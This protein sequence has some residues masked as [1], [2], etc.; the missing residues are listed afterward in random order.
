MTDGTPVAREILNEELNS[1]IKLCRDERIAMSLLRTFKQRETARIVYGDIIRG[2]RIETVTR[3]I[4]YLAEVIC[5]A[6]FRG[7]QMLLQPKY[8]Q[9]I[10]DTG[11]V[12]Q[13]TVL[14]LGKLGG[15]E[16]N[17]SSDIDLMFIYGDEGRTN[18][19]RSITNREYF[20]KL[21]RKF[22][23]LLTETTD[24][25][26]CYRVDL[27]LRPEGKQGPIVTQ[28]HSALRYYSEKG[29]TWERQAFVKARPVAGAIELGTEF[30]K[31]MIPWVYRR[32]L[33][34]AD[35]TGIKALKRR[36]ERRA[37]DAGSKYSDVKTG[38]G[39][40]RDI[41]FSIQFLQLLN[42][43][44]LPEIRTGNTLD[45][46]A[47][48]ESVG[49]LTMQERSILAEN[50][51]FLRKI[52][53]RLQMLFDLQTHSLPA[54]DDELRKLAIRMGMPGNEKL[55]ALDQ[56]KTEFNDRTTLNRKIL[57]HLLHDAFPDDQD[58]DPEVDLI[59][60]PDANDE[61]IER[62]LGHYG[63][64]HV[65]AA[66][67]NLGS[68]A[69]ER[70]PFLSTRRC[71]HFLAAIAPQL[72]ATISK[73]PDPDD[74][75]LNLAL[76]SDSLGG[77]SALW[78]LFSTS[79][80]SL[81]LYVRLCASS[82]YLSRLLI[83]NPGMIDELLDSLLL[84]RL[85]ERDELFE[86]LSFRCRGA[87][88]IEP[89]LHSF[90]NSMHLRVG[91]RDI[92]GKEDIRSTTAALADIAE[93]CLQQVADREFGR[94]VERLG[95]PMCE[96]DSG[97]SKACEF[98]ILGMGKLGGREPNYHSDLDV[99][100]LYES[101]GRT[102]ADRKE[103]ETT[104]QHFFSQ[105]GQR[106]IKSFTRLD[107][108]G[109]L[110]E[111][112]PR[113]RPTGPNGEL[114]GPLDA[115]A[116]YFSEGSGQLWERQ[117]LCKARPVFGSD[118][119]R[120][121]AMQYVHEILV[122]PPWQSSF[123]DDICVMRLKLQESASEENLK[124]GEGGTVDIEFIVQMLQLKHAVSKPSVLVTGTLDTISALQDADI[125]SQD[126]AALMSESYRYLRS[127]ESRLRLMNTTARHDL[128]TDDASLIRLGYLLHPDE[129]HDV[130]QE[131]LQ[132]RAKIRKA[133][134]RFF[135]VS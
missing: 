26:F 7:A 24:R 61:M 51:E 31:K 14:A 86:E 91:V 16:L 123:A 52:E 3:Q 96:T 22:V 104:N 36:I 53:H 83:S 111:M 79:Q 110:Y 43:G 20:E 39:G 124:R 134:E 30:L 122:S 100:F 102:Q 95:R 2:Q 25:G 106:I 127:L 47:R 85:P 27:R 84:D 89:I 107:P 80:A 101:R 42:G 28:F 66:Y 18:G 59:L 94:L 98:I 116:R 133:F 62:V 17:Y 35:I 90:K 129:V 11:K 1:E 128:P 117:A 10:D 118:A 32:Y 33:S 121:L 49:C 88:D 119:A 29:R 71:R 40:I 75:L 74:T 21:A 81:R 23:Q 58:T 78:E 13:F 46:I 37:R 55:S 69:E 4:S 19:D 112:D 108:H 12:A 56:F 70:I 120:R 87:E 15:Q 48:L 41:E 60:D 45:A 68:L 72:L 63:F 67:R 97:E 76:V 103:I 132:V 109:R 130:R 65:D 115:F 77:K 126:D 131:S 114:A 105:L 38:H 34:R 125:I 9:P 8:G 6:A 54:S 92:L 44:D 64:H 93:A 113:L 57:D 135:N 50:Y 99:I 73:T 82:P 5:A